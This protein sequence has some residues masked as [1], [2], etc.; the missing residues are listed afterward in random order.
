MM[1]KPMNLC[2]L[3]LLLAL[4]A[5]ACFA[6]EGPRGEGPGSPNPDELVKRLLEFDRNGD[7]QLSKEELPERLQGLF[8]RG[9]ANKDGILSKDELR[10]LAEAQS[11]NAP[12]NEH[13]DHHEGE[14][15]SRRPPVNQ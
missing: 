9:D 8:A 14:R 15:P 12:R 5:A 11:A 6:Q 4:G 13:D 3:P 7:G 1:G 10:K 2:V